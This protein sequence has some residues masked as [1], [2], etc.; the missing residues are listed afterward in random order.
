MYAAP[1]IAA[2][3][4]HHRAVRAGQST[5]LAEMFAN[6]LNPRTTVWVVRKASD[7]RVARRRQSARKLPFMP[8]VQAISP[9]ENVPPGQSC[10]PQANCKKA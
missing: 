10:R 9:A 3:W 4:N 7:L 1:K 5:E 8:A 2:Q 6:N